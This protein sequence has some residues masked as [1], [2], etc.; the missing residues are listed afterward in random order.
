MVRR[1]L[2][3]AGWPRCNPA[4]ETAALGQGLT[5]AARACQSTDMLFPDWV[6]REGI[7]LK[8]IAERCGGLVSRASVT[9]AR[10]GKALD[11]FELA[12]TLSAFTGGE[13]TIEEI[14]DPTGE[15]RKRIARDVVPWQ[16]LQDE[17]R[18][19]L[20]D[21]ERA[22]ELTLPE[23]LRMAQRALDVTDKIREALSEIEVDDRVRGVLQGEND[24]TTAQT[25]AQ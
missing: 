14:S 10:D 21:A 24:A 8:Q 3:A 15:I 23:V 1:A 6:A 13:C 18:V 11:T 2:G 25:P 16:R 4:R 22:Q 19:R 7:P 20:R 5:E 9:N 17:E 12:A